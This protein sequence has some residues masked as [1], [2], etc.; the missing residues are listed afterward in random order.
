MSMPRRYLR[1]VRI[2][3]DPLPMTGTTRRVDPSSIRLAR[4][5]AILTDVPAV[6]D[7]SIST[8]PRLTADA[9]CAVTAADHR[10]EATIARGITMHNLTNASQ[11]PF[12]L[13]LHTIEQDFRLA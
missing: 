8:T 1:S 2:C 12:Q 13:A 9:C 11:P 6:P 5:S 10:M 3:S 7:V 4:S